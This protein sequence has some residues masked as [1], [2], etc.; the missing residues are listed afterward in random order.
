[1]RLW[2]RWLVLGSLATLSGIQLVL[3]MLGVAHAMNYLRESSGF[4][5]TTEE[6][7]VL[8]YIGFFLIMGITCGPYFVVWIM[9]VRQNRSDKGRSS[10]NQNT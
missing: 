5:D 9:H 8:V 2:L 7:Q 3:L 4:G 6:R 10:D 1:M